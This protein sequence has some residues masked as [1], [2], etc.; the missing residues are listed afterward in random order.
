MNAGDNLDKRRLLFETCPEAEDTWQQKRLQYIES[1]SVCEAEDELV[2]AR[3]RA[4]RALGF[5]PAN[6]PQAFLLLPPVSSLPPPPPSIP[7]LPVCLRMQDKS[8][9]TG[10]LADVSSEAVRSRSRGSTLA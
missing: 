8:L 2:V 3:L 10:T 5:L 7:P 6:D 4:Q 1:I 9:L